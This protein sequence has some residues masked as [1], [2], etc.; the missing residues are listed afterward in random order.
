[1]TCYNFAGL[2]Q[3]STTKT[4]VK[5][6]SSIFA[7]HVNPSHVMIY[8]I[9]TSSVTVYYILVLCYEYKYVINKGTLYYTESHHMSTSNAPSA[10]V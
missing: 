7:C 3:T 5:T 6:M 1:M 9:E 10:V 2:S 4:F 8:D